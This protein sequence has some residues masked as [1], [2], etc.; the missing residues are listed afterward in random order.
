[1]GSAFTKGISHRS[2]TA[3]RDALDCGFD[4]LIVSLDS[5]ER[6]IALEHGKGN[7]VFS[8]MAPLAN[9]PE[10]REAVREVVDGT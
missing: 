8:T 1:M 4:T 5:A 6:W 2:A 3:R 9:H 7:L 10:L